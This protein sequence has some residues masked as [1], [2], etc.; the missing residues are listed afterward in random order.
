MI[1]WEYCVYSEAAIIQ[2]TG[3]L[4][5]RSCDDRFENGYGLS[6][7]F[8]ISPH[9]PLRQCGNCL[10]GAG[11]SNCSSHG[12]KAELELENELLITGKTS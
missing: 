1:N 8:I 3:D 4:A 7:E 6:T 9:K 11:G 10:Y 2:K 5:P 12:S